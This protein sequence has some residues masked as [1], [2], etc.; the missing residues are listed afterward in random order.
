MQ[1]GAEICQESDNIIKGMKRIYT[2]KWKK[3]SP[4]HFIS[5]NDGY[6]VILK[7]SVPGWWNWRITKN[8][9]EIDCSANHSPTWNN[10]LSVKTQ[11]EQALLKLMT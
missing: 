7:L 4:T 11:A 2:L 1:R 9:I 5:E 3:V 6:T 8:Q 10:E